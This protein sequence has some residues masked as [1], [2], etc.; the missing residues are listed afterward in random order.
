MLPPFDR[1]REK[2]AEM[3][4]VQ[5]TLNRPPKAPTH[6]SPPTAAW[7]CEVMSAFE[8]EAHHEHL[9][10]LACEALDRCEQARE[11]LATHGMTHTDARGVVRARPEIQIERDSK[12]TFRQLLREPDLDISAPSSADFRPP[13]LRSNRR[14]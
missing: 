4:V 11:A 14:Y 3:K 2:E 9:L 5:P 6:L 7:Y 13:G 12:T 10:R 1:A 8:L